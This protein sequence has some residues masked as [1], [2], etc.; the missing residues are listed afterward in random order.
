VC[1]FLK[2]NDIIKQCDN[3]K[4]QICALL[5]FY[6]VLIGSFLGMFLGQ[7]IDSISEVQAVDPRSWNWKKN[8]SG[9]PCRWVA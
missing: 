4:Y 7:P 2:Q 6:A 9:C 1:L 3:Y 8:G 5:G